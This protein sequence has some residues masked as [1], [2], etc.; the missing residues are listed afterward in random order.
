MKH[1]KRLLHST[2]SKLLVVVLLIALIPVSAV[3]GASLVQRAGNFVASLIPSKANIYDLGSSTLKWRNLYS[4]GVITTNATSS[5]VTSGNITLSQYGSIFYLTGV[6]NWGTQTLL[7]VGG[8]YASLPTSIYL[9]G[10][11]STT[12]TT[13]AFTTTVGIGSPGEGEGISAFGCATAQNLAGG[14]RYLEVMGDGA[15]QGSVTFPA[16]GNN[17]V[18]LGSHAAACTAASFTGTYDVIV[19]TFSAPVMTSASYNTILGGLCASQLTTGTNNII[20]GYQG[21][22]GLTT[23]A[24]NVIIGVS[25]SPVLITGSSN[26]FIGHSS[27][28]GVTGNSTLVIDQAGEPT[29]TC[30]LYGDMGSNAGLFRLSADPASASGI[31]RTMQFTLRDQYWTGAATAA[32]DFNILHDMASSLVQSSNVTFST[33]GTAI[34]KLEMLNGTAGVY[35]SANGTLSKV[36][37]GAA[38]SGGTGFRMLYVPN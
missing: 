37:M 30:F 12:N 28:Q 7:K 26:I 8:V 36:Y 18:I 33:N 11:N 31:A 13:G 9:S 15:L 32:W 10:S 17:S 27:G 3:N 38:D 25:T 4:T 24:N 21:S 14:A 29:A 35:I 34:M 19:G 22:I 6:T 5:N 1:L 20:V 23:G 2:L 16:T